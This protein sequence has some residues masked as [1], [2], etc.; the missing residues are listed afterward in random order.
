MVIHGIISRFAI[1]QAKQ[2]YQIVKYQDKIIDRTYRK[3]GLYNRGVVKGIQ[4]GLAGG[5]IVGG[6]ASLGLNTD[7]QLNGG[8]GSIFP[9]KPSKTGK[10]YKTRRRFPTRTCPRY[11]S[12][13]GPG[14]SYRRPQARKY[15]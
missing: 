6:V 9:R 7:N 11:T 14:K 15:Y 1:R 12:Y 2:L 13:K 10:P 4:H 5:Q 8:N 3:A